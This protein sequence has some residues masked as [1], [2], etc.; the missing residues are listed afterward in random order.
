[1]IG[2]DSTHKYGPPAASHAAGGRSPMGLG[3][4]SL[5]DFEPECRLARDLE[6]GGGET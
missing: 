1:M 2:P 3:P 4:L 5:P 6:R